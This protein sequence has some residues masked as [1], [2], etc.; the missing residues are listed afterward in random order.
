MTRLCSVKHTAVWLRSSHNVCKPVRM[1][2]GSAPN[3]VLCLLSYRQWHWGVPCGDKSSG[4]VPVLSSLQ[5]DWVLDPQQPRQWQQE[6]A[7]LPCCRSPA[8]HV[9]QH[10]QTVLGVC[11]VSVICLCLERKCLSMPGWLAGWAGCSPCY[12]T[13][14]CLTD[15]WVPRRW[16][17]TGECG[18]CLKDHECA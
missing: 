5:Q 14:H 7:D 17:S 9:W 15:F 18:H 12:C 13:A 10:G 16:R 2:V 8:Q 6:R 11:T 3:S 1:C 4:S